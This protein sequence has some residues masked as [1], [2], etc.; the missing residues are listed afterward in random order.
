[1][2]SL[3]SGLE[4]FWA[5]VTSTPSRVEFLAEV[6]IHDAMQQKHLLRTAIHRRFLV[7]KGTP[8]DRAIATTVLQGLAN[9][10]A[11]GIE[12]T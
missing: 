12:V 1:M 9:K 2:T 8:L 3:I 4:T 10:T 6:V 11:R 7:L 5:D